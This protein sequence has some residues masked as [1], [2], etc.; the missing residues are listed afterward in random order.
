M[1]RE[2][3]EEA[4]AGAKRSEAVPDQGEAL[5]EASEGAEAL[6]AQYTALAAELQA[7]RDAAELLR[8]SEAHA[9]R[10]LLSGFNAWWAPG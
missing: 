10:D 9:V 2:V 5:G 4:G 1:Q 8:M 6:R 7:A 3:G